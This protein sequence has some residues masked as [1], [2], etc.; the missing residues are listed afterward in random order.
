MHRRSRQM[1]AYIELSKEIALGDFLRTVR[2]KELEISN[3]QREQE[4]DA[5]S[6]NR[7]YIATVKSKKRCNHA[8]ILEQLQ[9]IPGVAFLEEL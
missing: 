3:V 1:E 4:T 2:E 9:T 7:A 5:D 8:Q 6:G